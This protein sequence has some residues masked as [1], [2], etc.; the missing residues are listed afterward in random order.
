MGQQEVDTQADSVGFGAVA[1]AINVNVYKVSK[2]GHWLEV[3][4]IAYVGVCVESEPTDV[5]VKMYISELYVTTVAVCLN[6]TH[7][8]PCLPTVIVVIINWQ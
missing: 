6:V 5:H 3:R 2:I 8:P 1:E 7:C 4:V